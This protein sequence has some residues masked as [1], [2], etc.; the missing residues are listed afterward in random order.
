MVKIPTY[1]AETRAKSPITRPRPM[2]SSGATEVYGELAR[3]ADTIGDVAREVHEKN[4]NIEN[5]RIKTEQLNAFTIEHTDIYNKHAASSDVTNG[6]TNYNNDVDALIESIYA[7]LKDTNPQVAEYL[8]V[9]LND[10]KRGYY[11][12]VESSIFKNNSLSI[13]EDTND[14]TFQ[15][16]NQWI[17]ADFKN[18]PALKFNAEAYMFGVEDGETKVRGIYDFLNDN[19]VAPP[20]ITKEQFN[21]NLK[22]D[23]KVL[24][25]NKL[26]NEDLE[27]FY[28]IY[29]SGEYNSID[30]K[31]LIQ[32][33]DKADGTLKSINTANTASLTTAKSQV[34][35]KIDLIMDPVKSGFLPDINEINKVYAEAVALN[36][37]LIA[38]GKV[39]IADKIMELENAIDVNSFISPFLL[40]PTDE[41]YNG[42]SDE[43]IDRTG[44]DIPGVTDLQAM[45]FATQGT[46]DYDD[47][48]R[49]KKEALEKIIDFRESNKDNL[50]GIAQQHGV[51]R[52]GHTIEQIDWESFDLNDPSNIKDLQNRG[53]L[54]A[55]VSN[56]YQEDP[57]FFLSAEKEQINKIISKGSKD[58]IDTI[59]KAVSA[60]A[61][62]DAPLAFNE[63]GIDG[64]VGVAHLGT[65]SFIN[66]QAPAYDNAINAF[67]LSQSNP[68]TFKN[69]DPAQ[70]GS[71]LQSAAQDIDIFRFNNIS[72]D[73]NL[74]EQIYQ[75]AELIFYGKLMQNPKLLQIPTVQKP[76]DNAKVVELYQESLNIAAGNRNGKGGLQNYNGYQI[77][78]PTWLPNVEKK[79]DSTEFD[80]ILSE[81]MTDELLLKAT[82][83][84]NIVEHI[85]D[86]NGDITQRIIP[87]SE[88][89][90]QE[91][92]GLYSIGDNK[93]ILTF[94][95]PMIAE[96][97]YSNELGN[98]VVIDFNKIKREILAE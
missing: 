18:I 30:P 70:E 83:G 7:P 27:R 98:V 13:K 73:N 11:P 3:F 66:G 62:D 58:D 74:Y 84:Q 57:Q 45:L 17:D 90:G 94:G 96:E 47:L 24:Q 16:M 87:A 59:I 39:G 29:N 37:M 46:E 71:Q 49:L 95:N 14:K 89:F 6:P 64:F 22:N 56:L 67:I 93:Y 19:G 21:D 26:I 4:K 20:G 77:I 23:L 54:S 9:K 40:R 34:I 76:E 33:K 48:N 78:I 52:Y 81:K 61:G 63:L 88:I 1:T 85:E 32:L 5:D 75:S 79:M 65:L 8:F 42:Y 41:L 28:E 82:G 86:I 25:A 91:E 60:M 53:E 36:E 2:V 51:Q 68:D 35:D 50:L 80:E 15:L 10:I 97:A 55:H 44:E 38:S 92:A 72:D 69:F 43:S 31:T 12:N